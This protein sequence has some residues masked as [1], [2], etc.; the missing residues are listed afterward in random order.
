MDRRIALIGFGEAA[1]A[2]AVAGHWLEL[3][4]AFDIDPLRRPAMVEAGVKVS[5]HAEA[6]LAGAELIL[7][8]VTADQALA[9]AKAYAPLLEKGAIWCDMNS[10]AP[11]TKR[12]AAHAIDAAGGRYVDVAILAP[13]Y[14]SG[15]KV[16]LLL[17]GAA[18]FDACTALVDCGFEHVR[19]VGDD[20]GKASSIKMIRSVMVKGVEALTDEMIAAA[21]AAGVRDEVLGSLDRSDPSQLWAERAAY[22]IERM[23]THGTRRASE[24]EE[25]VKTLAALGVDPIM[26]RGTVVR[27]RGAAE[28]SKEP[29]DMT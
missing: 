1:A 3:V 24:M 15:M 20:V 22:N 27:Q 28:S 26:T 23:K 2:F 12:D 18:S 5:D 16:P 11:T 29:R 14:P 9:A 4:S 17:S 6:A 10:V 19:M 8:L 21:D 7:S 25:S 13:V